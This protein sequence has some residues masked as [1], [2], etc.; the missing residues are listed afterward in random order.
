MNIGVTEN[1]TDISN[2]LRAFWEIES[3]GI[4]H[5]GEETLS[6]TEA[7][8]SFD[9]SV[10]FSN[11]RYK[12]AL[13]WRPNVPHLPD[14]MRVAQKRFQ[15]L[16]RKLKSDVTLFERYNDVIKDY[17]QQG[18]CENVPQTSQSAEAADNVTYYLP[19]HV[20][21]REDKLTTKL[22]VVFDASSHE[23]G[24]PSLND[25]LLAGPNLNPDLMS[26]LIRFRQHLVAF[27]ADITKAFLQ[28][29]ITESDRDA[30]RFLWLS[31]PPDAETTKTRTMRMTRVV[32]GVTSSPFLLA[33]TIR[34]HLKK[35]EA[36]HPHAVNLMMDSLYV[37]DLIASSG[38]VD[39][40]YELTTGAK[41]IMA[42]ANMNFCKWTT[43]VPELKAMWSNSDLDFTQET[44]AHGSVLKVLGLVWRPD[45]DDFVFDL[46]HLMNILKGK[47][48]TKR[49]VLRSSARIF[50]PIV[51]LT[52]FTIRVKCL[53]QEMWRQGLRWDDE[54]PPELSQAWQ[55]WCM[56]LPQIHQIVIPRWY[57]TNELSEQSQVLH[58]FTDAGE[59]AYG[60][61]AYLQGQ[62]T[63][64]Q[65]GTR[66]TSKS[67]VAPSRL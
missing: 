36:I 29:S 60:A 7:K 10:T 27:T 38:D 2:Q 22:R 63:D 64:G 49:S 18:V 45:T 3:L 12:V 25:C 53:F 32:F 13:P 42:D 54:L 28:I 66:P 52:P 33:A 24:C 43:N 19:H 51:F 16:K 37:D 1:P 17:E 9:R 57:G 55:Q 47:D 56:E 8:Q 35:Y 40:A 11:G 23:D 6:D 30:V 48:N 61:A 4:T 41:Q 31:G 15:T 44:E 39:Q 34:H 59:K 67:R 58:V 65:T 26:I 50:D 46:K 21:I 62:T 20:V 14:N 5:K